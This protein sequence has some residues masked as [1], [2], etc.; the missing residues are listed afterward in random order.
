VEQRDTISSVYPGLLTCGN[1]EPLE[2]L[3]LYLDPHQLEQKLENDIGI[4]VWRGLGIDM[5]GDLDPERVLY[6]AGDLYLFL[7]TP[8]GYRLVWRSWM[9]FDS[10]FHSQF[11]T[12]VSPSGNRSVVL[13]GNNGTWEYELSLDPSGIPLFTR[14]SIGSDSLNIEDD[15]LMD[16]PLYDGASF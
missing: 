9:N 11:G 12:Q 14:V 4:P 8:T 1:S 3:L 13:I 5:N 7:G 16:S 6:W 10:D 15:L 2:N